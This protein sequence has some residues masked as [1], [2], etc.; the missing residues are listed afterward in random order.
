MERMA[1]RDRFVLG[2][3]E[4]TLVS[5]GAY[6]LDGGAF[7]GVVPK[8]LWSRKKPADERN[9][10]RA[11]LNCLLLNSGRATVLVETGMGEKLDEKARALHEVERAR[12]LPEEIA[13]RGL[14]PAS[15]QLVINTHLHFDHCGGNTRW[16]QGAGTGQAVP[17]FSNARYLAQR[18][19]W[20]HARLRL[21]R[22]RVSYLAEN[23]D[24][25]VEA[26]RMSLIEGDCEPVPGIRVVVVPGHTRHMQVV[27]VQSGGGTCAFFSDLIPSTAHLTPTW[28]MAYDL[29]PLE[30]IEN[31]KRLLAQAAA[32]KWLCVFVHDAEHPW[33]YVRAAERGKYEFEPLK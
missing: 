12:S 4:L 1:Q 6:S 27:L 29:F 20:E 5:D 32:E 26:G 15:I 14:D 22:D 28:V 13:A 11:G 18:G 16:E 7:F 17:V 25:L 3:Y 9:R 31:K 8:T 19:E 2:N 33:G 23:Y 21:D 10:V 24:P 30:S